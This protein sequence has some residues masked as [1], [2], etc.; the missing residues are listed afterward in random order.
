MKRFRLF[1]RNE[2][3][4]MTIE[5]VFLFPAIIA[6]FFFLV[7]IGMWIYAKVVVIDSARDGARHAALNLAGTVQSTVDQ[8]IQDGRL[9]PTNVVSVNVGASGQ[10]TQVT[11]SYKYDFLF[12]GISLLLGGNQAY[13]NSYNI[14]ETAIF[15]TES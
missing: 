7:S 3:G 5:F 10:Y 13:A 11:V 4:T 8:S 2:K 15:K 6:S 12:P 14:V 9:D 1:K